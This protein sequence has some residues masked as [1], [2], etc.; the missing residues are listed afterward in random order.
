MNKRA[1]FFTV[2]AIFFIAL[3]CA[4][5]FALTQPTAI[6]NSKI[7]TGTQFSIDS[8]I[9]TATKE[10]QISIAQ[11]STQQSVF[12]TLTQAAL[13]PTF[14]PIPTISLCEGTVEIDYMLSTVPVDALPFF[15]VK[16]GDTINIISQLDDNWY[17]VKIGGIIGWI[18][19]NKIT[20]NST[21]Q[22]SNTSLANVLGLN[23]RTIFEDTFLNFNNWSY[24]S[25]K[26]KEL[27]RNSI[28]QGDFSLI[29]DD[30]YFKEAT[31]ENPNLVSIANFEVALAF[32]RQNGGDQS[33][34]GIIYGDQ[35]SSFS[36]RIKGDC[37]IEVQLSNVQIPIIQETSPINNRCGDEKS[38]FVFFSW[39]GTNLRIRI[40]DDPNTYTIP[41]G[42]SFPQTGKLELTVYGAKVQIRFVSITNP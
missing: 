30:G 37:K 28:D 18:P 29:V 35:S 1:L 20:V 15:K 2:I 34:V 11:T 41:L 16:A 39:D 9:A 7:A 32:N 36:A 10:I 22:I 4:S 42:T 25:N 24:S 38:D 23:G 19:K 5:V 12:A 8:Q 14:T 17:Q 27:K 31:L 40:N 26:E 3:I 21:C 33:Y 13:P 6:K